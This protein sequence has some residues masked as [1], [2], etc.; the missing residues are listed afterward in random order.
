MYD[1][2]EAVEHIIVSADLATPL[3][4]VAGVLGTAEISGVPRARQV[5]MLTA[6]GLPAKAME[7]PDFPISLEQ[8]LQIILSWLRYMGP[9]ASSPTSIF[10]NVAWQD[11]G[12]FGL[13]GLAMQHAPSLEQALRVVFEN[14]QLVWGHTR[15]AVT[16]DG[17]T[18]RLRLDPMRS[19]LP[20]VSD[21]DNARLA[22][23]CLLWDV[24]SSTQMIADILG[25][26]H[27][28]QS[29]SLPLPKPPDWR[30]DTNHLTRVVRF[31][32]E[33]AMIAYPA[34]MLR[35]AP[36]KANRVSFLFYLNESRKLCEALRSDIGLDEQ[37]SRWLWA[38]TPPMRCG[39]I[40]RRLGMSERSL[41][42]G[43]HAEGTSYRDLLNQV[44]ADR[45]QNLLGDPAATVA[46]VAYRLG[47][48]DPAAFSRAFVGWTGQ[49]PGSWR[50]ARNLGRCRGNPDAPVDRALIPINP[51]S[52]R[53]PASARCPSSAPRRP[54]PKTAPPR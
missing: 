4:T 28:P 38:S 1:P 43:L 32:A 13:V 40:A 26:Q 35:A 52:S 16:S 9:G 5:E 41:A 6:A 10:A 53:R 34:A 14:A 22:E 2:A 8:E 36:L 30:R 11:I 24:A 49:T 27:W 21:E 47:Y 51:P 45:A 46:S 7:T 33:Q 3:R 23:L 20:M 18:M 31:D 29:V 12:R 48:S 15:L 44:Q 39:E 37:V 17:E 54:R 42:R 50:A 19:S 25:Q